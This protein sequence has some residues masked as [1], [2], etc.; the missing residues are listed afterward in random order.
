MRP[1]TQTMLKTKLE[2]LLVDDREENLLALAGLLRRDDAILVQARSGPEALELLLVHEIALALVDVHMPEMDGFELAELMRGT[3]RTREIPIIF[4]TAG[5]HDQSRMFQGYELGAVD[6]LF[7][8]LDALVLNSKVSVFVQLSRQKHELA[9][10]VSE[11]ET[12]LAAVPAA[13]VIAR[14]SDV[15]TMDGNPFTRRLLRA[16]PGANLSFGAPLGQRLPVKYVRNGVEVPAED[17]P[18]QQAAIEGVDVRDYDFDLIYEDGE[19]RHLI[20]N[21]SPLRNEAGRR[22][23]AIGAFVDITERKRATE[24]LARLQK[25]DEELVRALTPSQVADVMFRHALAYVGANGLALHVLS[26]SNTLKVVYETGVNEDGA[27]CRSCPALETSSPAADAART[28]RSVWLGAVDAIE[29]GYPRCEAL[30]RSSLPAAMAALPLFVDDRIIGSLLLT[31]SAPQRFDAEDRNHI[32]VLAFRCAQGLERA[33]SFTALEDAREAATRAA[34]EAH[35]RATELDAVFAAMGDAMIVFDADG[36]I[37][38][39]NARAIELFNICEQHAP[40]SLTQLIES[41]RLMFA[42]GR[43]LTCDDSPTARALRGQSVRGEIVVAESRGTRHWLSVSATPVCD[44]GDQSMAV[45]NFTDI[46][47]LHELQEQRDDLLRTISHDLRTPLGTLLLQAQ[48][49]E[50]ALD[51]Q[52]PNIRRVKAI[53]KSAQTIR[54]MIQDLVDMARLE[55]GQSKL[56]SK[57]LDLG[58]VVTELLERVAGI[59][60]TSRIRLCVEPG[61]PKLWIDPERL[62]RV[63]VNLLSNALKYSPSDSQVDLMVSHTAASAVISVVDRGTGIEQEEIP[64][65]FGRYYRAQGARKT[66]GLGLGLYITSLLVEAHGGTIEVESTVDQGSTFRVLLP[67]VANHEIAVGPMPTLF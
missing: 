61:V 34:E 15:T 36:S 48:L 50:R 64:L 4:I 10:R 19:T 14:D 47:R 5:I 57:L 12:L 63:I 6:F 32:E 38:K 42:D 56:D 11:L 1:E 17:L 65:L 20:G 37:K 18:V 27:V 39:L 9:I 29:R 66:D 21:A 52:D 7:K 55:S 51:T 22:S 44:E 41:A 33:N 67:L 60:D 31:F 45:S 26:S 43:S 28:G 24:R 25:V 23:G 49:V 46:T 58:T 2:I 53:L 59:L 35:R 13:V 3:E 54:V 30:R 8:P 40:Q 16:Q 62:E